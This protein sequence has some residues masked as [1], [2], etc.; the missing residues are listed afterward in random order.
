MAISRINDGEIKMCFVNSTQVI[1]KSISL[2][3]NTVVVSE[4]CKMSR[5]N[6]FA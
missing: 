1:T 4:V 6:R 3:Q 2:T 5:M